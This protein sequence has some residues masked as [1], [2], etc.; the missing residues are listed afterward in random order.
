MRLSIKTQN[1]RND[2]NRQKKYLLMQLKVNYIP[3]RFTKEPW[4]P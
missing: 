1:S 2:I 4:E 3:K